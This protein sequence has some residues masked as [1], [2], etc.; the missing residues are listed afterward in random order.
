MSRPGYVSLRY[1]ETFK[2]RDIVINE[3]EISD[4]YY[5]VERGSFD[6]SVTGMGAVNEITAGMGFG[7]KALLGETA[8][9]A[10]VTAT[11]KRNVAWTLDRQTLRSTLEEVSKRKLKNEIRMLQDVEIFQQLRVIR[12]VEKSCLYIDVRLKNWFFWKKL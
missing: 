4:K 8:R 9:T 6:V 12:F 2:I 1:R 7:V 11:Q 10:T 5:V 3:G